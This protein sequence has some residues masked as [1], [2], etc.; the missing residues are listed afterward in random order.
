MEDIR[1]L[2]DFDL[3]LFEMF[4]TTFS[5]IYPDMF[6]NK[7]LF[8]SWGRK[9]NFIISSLKNVISQK[10]K[11]ILVQ[12]LINT[13]IELLS[14][15]ESTKGLQYLSSFNNELFSAYNQEMLT[16]RNSISTCIFTFISYDQ[17]TKKYK[18]PINE[19]VK[20]VLNI[21]FKDYKFLKS[22]FDLVK[23]S[24]NTN[25]IYNE[26]L[27]ILNNKDIL[28]ALITNKNCV[29]NTR[30]KEFIALNKFNL[31]ES[32][33]FMAKLRALTVSNDDLFIELKNISNKK[34]K[35]NKKK[36]VEKNNKKDKVIPDNT[37][38]IDYPEDTL[39]NNKE[40]KKED[41]K[42]ESNKK[43]NI[44]E[45]KINDLYPGDKNFNEISD[46]SLPERIKSLEK[47][48]E[49]MIK[50]IQELEAI[51]MEER[52]INKETTDSLQANII[53]ERRRNKETTDSLQATIVKE[54][55]R[56]K[57]ITDNLKAAIVEERKRNKK[58]LDNL[59]NKIDICEIKISMI[60]YRDLIKEIINY[61]CDFF[62]L[63][64]KD[65]NTLWNK[66]IGL[67][68]L[69]ETSKDIKILSL[70]EKFIF[71]QFIYIS[72][73]TL[74]HVNH[75]VHDG[76]EGYLSD[77]SISNFMNCFKDYLELYLY[78]IL[79]DKR[80]SNITKF[81]NLIPQIK[82]IEVIIDKIGF[83]YIEDFDCDEL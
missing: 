35:K 20:E 63:Q 25:D 7:K 23:Y 75:K 56:N 72:F 48:N 4:E 14:D 51:I 30:Q 45:K 21:Y 82:D 28:E 74:N 76:E 73:L 77:Y 71:S 53:E 6:R 54:R 57:E 79:K 26:F 42:I 40:D 78:D 9:C 12:K 37:T 43:I 18:P 47:D 24:L 66:V 27:L 60:C 3:E 83:N 81:I 33:E 46:I 22:L 62:G 10:E 19:E 65:E 16:F 52:K 58:N 34:R 32:H 8:N 80:K 50:K 44:K 15:K 61:S 29:L 31:S 11:D 36:K 64:I 68:K 38:D 39:N 13:L 2:E 41:I 55:K 5:D 67:Q 70:N 1:T 69:L 59:E 17:E 49:L